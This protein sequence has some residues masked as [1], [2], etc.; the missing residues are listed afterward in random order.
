MPLSEDWWHPLVLGGIAGSFGEFLVQ[1]MIVVRTR[2]MVQGAHSGITHYAG[3]LDTCRTMLR[4][5]G[6]RSFYKGAALN[7]VSTPFARGLYMFGVELSRKVLGEGDAVRDFAAGTAG[8][9]LGSLAYVPRDVI[10]ERCAIDGQLQQVGSCA[11]SLTA[12]RTML[13]IEGPKGF[14]RAYMPHQVVWIP[15]NG[16]FFALYGKLQ[17]VE[18]SHG[19]HQSSFAVSMTNVGLSAAVAAWVTT[20]LDVVKTRVQVQ[21]ANPELFAFNGSLD[22]A[23]QLVK[24]EGVRALFSGSVAR[25]CY[26]V[27][28][29]S[30]FIPVYELLQRLVRSDSVEA[31]NAS[32]T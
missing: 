17:A 24:H 29:M 9:L 8:Q 2:M 27:P 23:R 30:V 7:V 5:E 21:G 25:V 31:P 18:T 22:C 28:N 13:A 14:Y 1:P 3:F 16:L 32:Q 10:I 12:F 11:N 20:P 4:T 26:M 6:P 15:Y 19:V